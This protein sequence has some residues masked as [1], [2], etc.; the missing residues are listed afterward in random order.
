VGV[1]RDL[2]LLLARVGLGIVLL[3]HG[4]QKY[5]DLGIGRTAVGFAQVGIPLPTLAAPVVTY[6]ELVGGALLIIGLL[7]PVVGILIALEMAGAI[8]FVHAPYGVFVAEGGWELA[9][10]TG[11]L[12]LTLAVFGS[13]RVGLDAL[14]FRRR[15][16]RH[17][18]EV[19]DEAAGE[20][21]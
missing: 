13:G 21:R 11:L 1:L 20:R 10:V 8:A 19:E 3:A 2:V 17:R 15:R 12:A 14:L 5:H 18:D 9:L 16:P 6:L 7:V 4:W